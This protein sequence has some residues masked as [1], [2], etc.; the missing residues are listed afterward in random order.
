[1][2]IDLK[3]KA[4]FADYMIVASGRSQ[5]HVAS[6]ADKLVD[7]LK[8]EGVDTVYTE[9]EKSSDWVLVDCIDVVVHI[10]RPELRA[11]YN[12]EKMWAVPLP[13]EEPAFA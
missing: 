2:T 13:K 7:A 8:K 1:M 5:R 11:F 4:D 10:F 3:G 9:G 6:L 12:L